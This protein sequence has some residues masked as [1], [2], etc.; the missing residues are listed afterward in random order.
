[1]RHA[2]Y[3]PGGSVRAIG[4]ASAGVLLS[5]APLSP[6]ARGVRARWQRRATVGV[7]ALTLAVCSSVGSPSSADSA[8]L[9]IAP[10]AVVGGGFVNVVAYAPDGSGALAGTDVAG[11]AWSSAGAGRVGDRWVMSGGDLA[12]GS[13][14]A[15]LP[16]RLGVAAIAWRTPDQVYAVTGKGP[17]DARLVVSDD[18]GG[19]W[20]TVPTPAFG[21][22]AGDQL[23]TGANT[24]P[25]TTGRLVAVSP[26]STS[27]YVGTYTGILRHRP[28]RATTTQVL[29]FASVGAGNGQAT[30]MASVGTG[31][32]ERVYALVRD[33][34]GS[35]TDT[36]T[37]TGTDNWLLEFAPATPNRVTRLRPGCLSGQATARPDELVAVSER[38]LPALYVSWGSRGLFRYGRDSRNQLGWKLIAKA[39]RTPSTCGSAPALSVS[40][41]KITAWPALDAIPGPGDG[42]TIV[43]AG[44][45]KGCGTAAIAPCQAIARVTV[46]RTGAALVTPLLTSDAQLSTV[47]PDGRPWWVVA[48]SDAD[49]SAPAWVKLRA[50]EPGY[51]EWVPGSLAIAPGSTPDAL[52]MLMAGRAGVWRGSTD[53]GGTATWQPVSAGLTS[54]FPVAAAVRDAERIVA[55]DLDRQ[56]L[57]SSDGL[58]EQAPHNHR[59]ATFSGQ[60]QGPTAVAVAPDGRI[61]VGY[62]TGEVWT[63]PDAWSESAS[64]NCW[65]SLGRPAAGVI[66]DLAATDDAVVAAVP[67]VGLLRLDAPVGCEA[68]TATWS[69]VA[70]EVVGAPGTSPIDLSAGPG[71]LF[72]FTQ[73]EG[74]H[75]SV[76]GGRTFSRV[77][78]PPEGTPVAK[79][80]GEVALDPA[81]DRVYVADATGV[82]RIDQASTCQTCLGIALTVAGAP[83]FDPAQVAPALAVDDA[84]RV[85]VATV[86]A[87]ALDAP[88]SFV[89][90][91]RTNDSEATDLADVTPSA[92]A[93]YAATTRGLVPIPGTGRMLLVSGGQGLSVLTDLGTVGTR[94]G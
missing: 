79:F 93:D 6:P 17:A 61:V 84:G 26:D 23:A 75:R 63:N 33:P 37:S 80:F 55:L 36:T 72:A 18:R 53:P 3:L 7:T 9:T 51:S 5:H 78:A 82:T 58:A 71:A 21:A 59:P 74:L 76:D 90:L 14:G 10:S 87:D 24:H 45:S 8:G 30:S 68:D 15:A 64:A 1:M 47:L 40:G 83:G 16:R 12:A 49:P 94:S 91:Y 46:P 50:A 85:V 62:G 57:V 44:I 2:V 48:R 43:I 65:R 66:S 92:Y 27:V 81:R 41:A 56:V 52:T 35:G 22:S 29:R 31:L 32:A 28:D 89:R 11:T 39:A 38:G 25:R 60:A 34:D 77:W 67:G 69:L 19:H 54:T 86:A 42:T 13:R 4:P 70:S 88:Q 20:H 73:G